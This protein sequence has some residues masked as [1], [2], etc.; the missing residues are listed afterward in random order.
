MRF[1]RNRCLWITVQRLEL[2]LVSLEGF[3]VGEVTEDLDYQDMRDLKT[4]DFLTIISLYPKSETS[5]R[6]IFYCCCFLYSRF[7][8][9]MFLLVE[10][11]RYNGLIIWRQKQSCV[12][13]VCMIKD[14]NKIKLTCFCQKYV[15]FFKCSTNQSKPSS[16]PGLPLKIFGSPAN[17]PP[18]SQIVNTFLFLSNN[19]YLSFP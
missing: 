5:S 18:P 17:P 8:C 9:V 10:I 13:K 3:E 12:V 7:K 4:N 19:I 16:F 2:L 11:Q 15:I 14:D 1:C 6:G